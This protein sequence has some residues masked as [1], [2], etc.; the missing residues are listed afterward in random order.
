[1]RTAYDLEIPI[2]PW[3][4]ACADR[5]PFRKELQE[6]ILHEL[7]S[8]LCDLLGLRRIEPILQE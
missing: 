3:S 2:L 1:M 6:I 4:V 5:I 8:L 7:M